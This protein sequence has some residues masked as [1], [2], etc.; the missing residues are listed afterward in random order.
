M[1]SDP[2][3]I[4]RRLRINGIPHTIVGVMPRILRLS[5]RSAG[6]AA[7]AEAGAAAAD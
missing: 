1:G 7:V 3:A 6:V 2:N 5:G 4:G